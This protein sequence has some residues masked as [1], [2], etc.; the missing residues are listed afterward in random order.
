MVKRSSATGET[1]RP[2]DADGPLTPG[3]VY[4]VTEVRSRVL[5][6]GNRIQWIPVIGPFHDDAEIIGFNDRHWHMDYRLT[7]SDLTLAMEEFRRRCADQPMNH[8]V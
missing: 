5:Q 8:P 7:S 1:P 6:A 3:R 4:H 2:Q